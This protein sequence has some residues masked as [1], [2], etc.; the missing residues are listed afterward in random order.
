MASDHSLEAV[1]DAGGP[2]HV[3]P[4]SANAAS[5]EPDTGFDFSQ[6]EEK[7]VR[8]QVCWFYGRNQSHLPHDREL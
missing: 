4:G 5:N 7:D 6:L 3:T 8:Q 1:Q 2:P